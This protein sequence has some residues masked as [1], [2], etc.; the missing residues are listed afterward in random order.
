MTK[1]EVKRRQVLIEAT[2]YK[3]KASP[4]DIRRRG[5]NFINKEEPHRSEHFDDFFEYEKEFT[6]LTPARDTVVVGADI[7]RFTDTKTS[8]SQSFPSKAA[9]NN[10]PGFIIMEK[11]TQEIPKSNNI[12]VIDESLTSAIAE[13]S[14]DF[15][16]CNFEKND[17]VRCKKQAKKDQEYCGIHRRFIEKNNL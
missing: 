7:D 17:G 14:F 5:D 15:I 13:P 1:D 6:E 8:I 2:P 4:V 12:V 3:D 9:D 16:Q 11:I 10:E